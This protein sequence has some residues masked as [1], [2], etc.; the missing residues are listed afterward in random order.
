MYQNQQIKS[1]HKIRTIHK[2]FELHRVTRYSQRSQE[3][4]YCQIVRI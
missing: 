1:G 3:T 2:I 4:K